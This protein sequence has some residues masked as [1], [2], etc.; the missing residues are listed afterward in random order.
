MQ[1]DNLIIPIQPEFK[2]HNVDHIWDNIINLHQKRMEDH[3]IAYNLNMRV[4]DVK[5]ILEYIK[6]NKKDASK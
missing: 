2:L 1:E 4:E 6:K 3:Q 5:D